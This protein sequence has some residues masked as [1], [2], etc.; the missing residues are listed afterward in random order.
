LNS[1]FRPAARP[2]PAKR[3]TTA[4]MNPMTTASSTTDHST[5]RRDPPIVRTVANSRVRWATVI[6]R[7]LKMTN[8]PT[9]RATPANVSRT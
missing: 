4:A 2:R 3:P 7:V 6:E 8:A 9:K 1:A 5:C